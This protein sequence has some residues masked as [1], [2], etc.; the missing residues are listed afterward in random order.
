MAAF[1]S[2]LR[3]MAGRFFFSPA[4]WSP[5]RATGGG[6]PVIDGDFQAGTTLATR[7]WTAL[8]QAMLA[9][10]WLSYVDTRGRRRLHMVVADASADAAG[11]A[12]LLVT[13]PIR[14]AGADGVAVDVVAPAGVFMLPQDEAPQMNIRA[15]S[16]GQVT[17]TMQEALA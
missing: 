10:D 12:A 6:A 15:P 2:S 7:G 9:G 5:R 14:R 17:I 4:Q 1:L 11:L 3:G 13:P 16:L 8:G